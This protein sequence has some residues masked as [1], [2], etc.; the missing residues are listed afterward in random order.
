MQTT[1][2]SR[3]TYELITAVISCAS[4]DLKQR[5]NCII[6]D[7]ATRTLQDVA[8]RFYLELGMYNSD[9]DGAQ[10]RSDCHL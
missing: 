7:E 9:F 5:K 4:D 6:D 2:Y 10:F 1:R 3:D 8:H